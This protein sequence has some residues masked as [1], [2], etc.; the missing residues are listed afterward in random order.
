MRDALSHY[1][2]KH[3]LCASETPPLKGMSLDKQRRGHMQGFD[4]HVA[5][6]STTI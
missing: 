5:Y 4:G 6:G 1:P 3:V 2:K